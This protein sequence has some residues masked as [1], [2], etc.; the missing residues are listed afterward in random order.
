MT[1]NRLNIE[2]SR[3]YEKNI[4]NLIGERKQVFKEEL[5]I[6]FFAH[7]DSRAKQNKLKRNVMEI[8]N[9]RNFLLNERRAKL[10]EFFIFD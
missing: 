10:F 6:D 4:Q 5:K 3:A 1:D 2:K 8:M 9:Q 7:A